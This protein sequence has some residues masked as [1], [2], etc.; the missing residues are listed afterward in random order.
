MRGR[1]LN[2]LAFILITGLVAYTDMKKCHKLPWP[3]RF[4]FTAL[5]FLMMELITL[6]DESLGN[7]T[8]IGF[9]IAIFVKELTPGSKGIMQDCDPSNAAG[10][11]QD[12]QFVG[13]FTGPGNAGYYTYSDTAQPAQLP[14]TTLA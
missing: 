11:A 12:A 1:N 8:S 5:T 9:V 6:A 14:G 13:D 10:Q 7:V 3:P 2:L 4:I